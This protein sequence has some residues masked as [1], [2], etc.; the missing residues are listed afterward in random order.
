MLHKLEPNVIL[1][2]LCC[3]C[4]KEARSNLCSPKAYSLLGGCEVHK[5]VRSETEYDMSHEKDSTKCLKTKQD[6]ICNNKEKLH[7]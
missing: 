4:T 6:R 7:E 3:W 2:P 1:C 5:N